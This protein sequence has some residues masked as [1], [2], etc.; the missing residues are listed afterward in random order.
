MY[1][2]AYLDSDLQPKILFKTIDREKTYQRSDNRIPHLTG[3]NKKSIKE[4]SLGRQK[5]NAAK[6]NKKT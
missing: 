6:N 1:V 2:N 5:V 4:Y 3:S